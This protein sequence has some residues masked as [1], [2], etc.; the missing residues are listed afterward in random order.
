MRRLMHDRM[1]RDAGDPTAA[2]GPGDHRLTW[3]PPDEARGTGTDT[4]TLALWLT[5]ERAVWWPA[6]G[7]L[8][9]ADMHLGKAAVFRSHG[10]PVPKGTTT[11]T[12]KRLSAVL[13]RTGARRLIVLG[14]FLHAK[15]SHAPATMAALRRWRQAHAGLDCLIVQGN[16]DRHAGGPP[17]DLGFRMHAGPL[18]IGRLT[19]AHEPRDLPAQACHDE[20]SAP[21]ILLGHMHPVITLHDRL[22]RLRLPCFLMKGSVL[23]L[24][25]FGAFTGGHSV[26]RRAGQAFVVA[27]RVIPVGRSS[28]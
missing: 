16:H 19:G 22:D 17:E 14:D 21:L 15:E 5:P 2:P 10:L 12:L 1:M 24:P 27:D 18:R 26:D 23:T 8:F 6:E 28:P 25:A 4:E 11:E 9:V 3:P 20:A 7:T 13:A